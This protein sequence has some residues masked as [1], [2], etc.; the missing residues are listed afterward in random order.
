MLEV[1]IPGHGMVSADYLVLDVNGTLTV[2]GSLLEGV[3]DRLA[4]LKQQLDVTLLT[5][6]TMSTAGAVA[7][8][9]GVRLVRLEPDDGGAQKLHFVQKLG[10]SRTIAV[11]NGYNDV[12]MLE[13]AALGIAVIQAEGAAR[14]ALLAADLVFTSI[15][16]AFDALLSPHRLVATLR[17]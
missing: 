2:D 16:E 15:R 17:R 8:M 1:T 3:A 11:G 9:L 5:A 4:R 12:L 7:A 10:A 6:D 14:N 13:A